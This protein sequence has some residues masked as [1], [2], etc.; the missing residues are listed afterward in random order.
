[1]SRP[2][3]FSRGKKRYL[4]SRAL[5]AFCLLFVFTSASFAQ[6][7]HSTALPLA[8]TLTLAQAIS[9]SLDHHPS[10]QV[11][12][13]RESVL[14]AEVETAKLRPALSVGLDME[15]VLGT[16]PFE[17]LDAAEMTF[18]LSSVIELGDKRKARQSVVSERFDHLD[19]Q[20]RIDA[21]ELL[22]KVARHYIDL[23]VVESELALAKDAVVLARASVK[24]VQQRV[25]A[26]A[27][28]EAELLKARAALAQTKLNAAQKQSQQKQLRVAL[29]LHWGVTK[30]R[31]E[32][33]AGSLFKVGTPGDLESFYQRALKNPSMLDLVTEKR[34]RNAELRLARSA[35]RRDIRWSVGARRFQ[36]PGETALVAGVSVPLFAGQ[37]NQAAVRAAEMKRDEVSL[38]QQHANHQLYA[39]LFDA[40]VQRKAAI[41][42]KQALETQVIPLLAQAV[43]A[44]GQSYERGRYSYLEWAAAQQD[45]LAARQSLIQLAAS[46]HFYQVEIEQLTAEPLEAREDLLKIKE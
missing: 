5:A 29:S 34:L 2:L 38:H 24:A 11:Y 31:F 43:E 27:S 45:L 32:R 15:N 20:R 28:P 40:F 1:M 23:L 30:P 10:L 12:K 3:F 26:G 42:A 21:L 35:S 14:K 4:S 41:E 25:R 39:Q 6:A 18:S 33:V 36:E 46:A 8:R 22:G 13:L 17:G 16:G 37:R 19:A 7:E 9:L 44:T